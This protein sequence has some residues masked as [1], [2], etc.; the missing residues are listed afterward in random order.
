[1]KSNIDPVATEN[2]IVGITEI[3]NNPKTGNNQRNRL[4]WV[5]AGLKAALTRYENLVQAETAAKLA[6]AAKA[7]KTAPKATV[8]KNVRLPATFGNINYKAA[9]KPVVNG[10]TTKDVSDAFVAGH[11]EGFADGE[12]QGY[13]EG[14]EDGTDDGYKEGHEAALY[15][16]ENDNLVDSTRPQV[17][18]DPAYTPRLCEQTKFWIVVS[19]KHI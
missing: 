9:V 6:K 1:M 7:A 17:Y 2:R 5:R 16:V 12:K 11:K 14:Y 15:E 8:A 13:A 3:I 10:I 18:L 19:V 4:V